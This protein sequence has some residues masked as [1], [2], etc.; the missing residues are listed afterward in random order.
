LHL[1]LHLVS[2]NQRPIKGGTWKKKVRCEHEHMWQSRRKRVR[3]L[4]PVRVL[5]VEHR[6]GVAPCGFSVSCLH[7]VGIA[8]YTCVL[9][10]CRLVLIPTVF[11]RVLMSMRCHVC[12]QLSCVCAARSFGTSVSRSGSLVIIWTKLEYRLA[13]VQPVA[14]IVG[15]PARRPVGVLF[16]ADFVSGHSK[17]GWLCVC[18]HVRAYV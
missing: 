3:T 9:C 15:L 8:S 16:L 12:V 10:V 4:W 14:Y 13:L 11:Y 18:V 6:V 5:W 2:A 7:C 1:V 17:C